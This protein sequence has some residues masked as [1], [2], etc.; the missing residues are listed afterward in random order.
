MLAELLGKRVTV[1]VSEASSLTPGVELSGDVTRLDPEK[2]PSYITGIAVAVDAPAG[3]KYHKGQII[4][5]SRA[6]GH[7]LEEILHG[8]GISVN[9]QLI[10]AG[11]KFS[12]VGIGTLLFGDNE[13]KDVP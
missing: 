4:V 7:S 1:V 12:A 10:G 13:P 6:Q 8:D 3:S 5:T 9:F 11:H 2:G